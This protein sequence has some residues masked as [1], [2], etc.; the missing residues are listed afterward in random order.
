M[1]I[2]LSRRVR[3][4]EPSATVNITRRAI[5]LRDSGLDVIALSAGEP[6]FDTPEH[7]KRAAI[8]AIRSGETKYTA[9]DGTARL[10]RAIAAKFLN[11]NALSFDPDQIVVTSGAKQACFNAC[12]AL[13]QEGDEVLIPAPYW[14]S[15]PDMVR[16]AG[17]RPVIVQTLPADDFVLRPD[18]VAAAITG[19]TR[20]LILNSPN[21]PTGAVYPRA[22]L[23]R[24]ADILREHPQ[25]A[26]LSD[27]IYEH[28]RRDGTGFA[29]LAAVAPD[30]A[31][32]IV[33]VN[34]LSKSHAMSGW[35]VGYAAGS[36]EVIRAITKL[37]SQSTTNASSVSQAAA[38]AALEGPQTL[39]HEMSREFDRRYER[40]Y[41]R[42][43]EIEGIRSRPGRG[44]FY[45]LPDISEAIRR[46]GLADD[47]AFCEALLDRQHLALVPGTAFG[48]PGHL[49]VSF[50]ASQRTLDEALR[51][52]GDFVA[53]QI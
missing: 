20:L 37:Q 39:V 35:R 24:L 30:L 34:G 21:N 14:V 38:C 33:T 15:Y 8:E 45:L 36:T 13:I 51:R 47:V 9:V 16:L 50:A 23:T 42:L 31:E 3:E 2:R 5:E 27:D 1:T 22:A 32:R 25:V 43:N 48:A 49:R 11:E 29:T 18:A 52:L 6:D 12:Q 10:K 7:V 46:L 17:A 41:T 26:V 53:E 28:I 4:L 44:A 40:V 19:R